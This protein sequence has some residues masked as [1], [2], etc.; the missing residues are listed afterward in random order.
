[1]VILTPGIIEHLE[2]SRLMRLM[3]L[4]QSRFMIADIDAPIHELAEVFERQREIVQQ[5][6]EQ[7]SATHQ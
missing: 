6:S 2:M 5:S 3:Y 4:R 7:R 1:M